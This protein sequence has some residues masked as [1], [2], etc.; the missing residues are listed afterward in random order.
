[1]HYHLNLTKAMFQ[2]TSNHPDKNI[3]L[4]EYQDI[5]HGSAYLNAVKS[6]AIKDNDMVL[7]LSIYGAQLYQSKQSD[8]WIYIWVVLDLALDVH[9]KKCHIFPG[10]FFPGP[11]K[12]GNIKSF[13]LPGLHHAAALM[14]EGLTIWD[15]SEDKSFV[16][17]IFIIL[18]LAD[19]PGLTYLNG[20][21][22]HS[23]TYECHLYCSVKGQHKDCGNH[24]YPAL[25]KP[26]NYSVEGSDRYDA[27]A[28]HLPIGNVNDYLNGLNAILGS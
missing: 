24:Y 20:L 26:V 19:G 6:G 17:D 8:C 16:S 23:S 12:P 14:K 1:M 15:A 7:M 11:N 10:G 22:G 25:L 13:L 5:F 9:Y 3:V 28:T 27:N 4:E 2:T 18:G 21:T